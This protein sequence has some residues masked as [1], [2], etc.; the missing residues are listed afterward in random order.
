MEPR[1]GAA[2][3]RCWQ[4]IRPPVYCNDT[5]ENSEEVAA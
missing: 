5:L 2:W 1:A 3:R 4:F